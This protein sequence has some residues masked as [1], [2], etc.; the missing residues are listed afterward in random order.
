MGDFKTEI[1]PILKTQSEIP[2]LLYTFFVI[3]IHKLNLH[4]TITLR[5][6]SIIRFMLMSF[7]SCC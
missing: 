6:F 4:V 7:Q 2:F 3:D 1:K 5:Y